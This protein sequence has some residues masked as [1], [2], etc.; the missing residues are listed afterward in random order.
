MIKNSHARRWP[1][2]PFHWL[3]LISLILPMSVSADETQ[4]IL[5]EAFGDYMMESSHVAGIITQE[6]FDS[7][8]ANTAKIFDGREAAQFEAGHIPGAIHMEWRE[9][10]DR[11]DEIPKDRPVVLYDGT[12]ALAAQAGFALRLLGYQNVV[13]LRGGFLEWKKKH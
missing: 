3:M 13:I 10:M 2:I 5:M 1:S 9:V 12:G 7:A 8:Y 11:I 6:Q 4:K